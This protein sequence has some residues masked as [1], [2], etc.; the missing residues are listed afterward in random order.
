MITG[1][2]RLKTNASHVRIQFRATVGALLLLY[3]AAGLVTELL[4]P[5]V[6]RELFPLSSWFLFKRVPYQVRGYEIRIR[7]LQG[8]ALDP[9]VAFNAADGLVR[10]PHSTAPYKIIQ[11]LGE[12][13]RRGRRDEAMRQRQLL[14]RNFLPP[15]T[16]YE[17]VE[18]I[19]APVER[20]RDGRVET[21]P[22][23]EFTAE[24]DEESPFP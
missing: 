8:R 16:R 12:S 5:P 3:L 14:E 10:M 13:I 7:E 24:P 23:A 19:Y 2:P 20:W 1:D 22:L 6:A 15:A 18:L 11:Q 9:P 4:P 21:I 17:I